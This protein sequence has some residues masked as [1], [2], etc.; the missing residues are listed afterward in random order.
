MRHL[1]GRR[2]VESHGPDNWIHHGLDRSPCKGRVRRARAGPKRSEK[3]DRSHSAAGICRLR[4]GVRTHP[5]R[6]VKVLVELLRR[7]SGSCGRLPHPEHATPCRVPEAIQ[8]KCL[9][10]VETEA[11]WIGKGTR[12]PLGKHLPAIETRLCAPVQRPQSNAGIWAL[13]SR[14]FVFGQDA[15]QIQRQQLLKL[16]HNQD[17]PFGICFPIECHHASDYLER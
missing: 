2:T 4:G 8:N 10:R 3:T 1:Y 15:S 14:R 7:G 11:R 13:L 16:S 17:F 5:R 6:N 12:P 9:R